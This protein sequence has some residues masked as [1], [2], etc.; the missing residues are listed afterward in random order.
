MTKIKNLIVITLLVVPVLFVSNAHADNNCDAVQAQLEAAKSQYKADFKEQKK[1][2]ENWSKYNK[3][4][5]SYSYGLTDEPLADSYINCKS[6]EMDNKDFCKG[7][8]EKY[9]EITSKEAPSKAEYDAAEDK[10][11]ASRQAYNDL[12]SEASDIGC[13]PKKK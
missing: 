3:E 13:N 9:D 5:H 1:A 11:D 10:A 12:V 4:L 6:G 2:F 7:V 8:M